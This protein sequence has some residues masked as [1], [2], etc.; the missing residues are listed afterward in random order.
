MQPLSR[1]FVLSHN[2]LVVS[3]SADLETSQWP[4]YLL[5]KNEK[6]DEFLMA[7]SST[8]LFTWE[9]LPWNHLGK[10]AD[11]WFCEYI[12]GISIQSLPQQIWNHRSVFWVRI[13]GTLLVRS[14]WLCWDIW[15]TTETPCSHHLCLPSPCPLCSPGHRLLWL[16]RADFLAGF[17]PCFAS[18]VPWVESSVVHMPQHHHS[19]LLRVLAGSSPA[20]MGP[21]NNLGPQGDWNK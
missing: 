4:F 20:A 7:C 6:L 19:L 11:P 9:K 8:Y 1:D 17:E 14:F 10:N 16:G 2:G 21:P 5:L 15:D 13:S 18:A 3:L 12:R